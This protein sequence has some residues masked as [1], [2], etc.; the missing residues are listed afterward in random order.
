MAD[1]GSLA[2][3]GAYYFL[4]SLVLALL[5][6]QI[7]GPHG[8]A[9]KLPTWRWAPA[10]LLR[11]AGRPLTGYHVWMISFI[12][13]SLHLPL[14]YGWSWLRHAEV[15]SFFFLIAV[16]W[17]FQWFL[18]NPHFGWDR[19]HRGGVWW[20]ARWWGGFPADY[21]TGLAAS[22]IVFLLPSISAVRAF[23]WGV[24]V[25]EFAVLTLLSF[26]M[27]RPRGARHQV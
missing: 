21:Y 18:L 26:L 27:L 6:I 22:G 12:L 16:F 10:R 3:R 25:A 17:D 20:Y 7:E 8:W 24:L 5:E 14:L 4:L 9:E 23:L 19:F 2:A 11:L 15:L 1:L 13:L